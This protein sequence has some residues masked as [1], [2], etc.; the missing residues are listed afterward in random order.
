[1]RVEKVEVK[2]WRFEAKD[3]GWR[4]EDFKPEHVNVALAHG[5][6]GGV[7]ELVVLAAASPS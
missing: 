1:M 3:V 6:L 7:D 2:G 5:E 4:V